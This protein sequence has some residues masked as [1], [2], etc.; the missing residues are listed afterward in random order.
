MNEIS[1]ILISVA[2]GVAI[3]V[4]PS[5]V[6]FGL[7]DKPKISYEAIVKERIDIYRNLWSKIYALQS[8]LIGFVY[9]SIPTEQLKQLQEDFNNVNEYYLI[10]QPF[11]T[12]SLFDKLK[13][14]HSELQSTFEN[15][16]I[17]QS[18][19][20]NKAQE[21]IEA[22][23]KLIAGHFQPIRQEIINQI[24]RDFHIDTPLLKKW[25]LKLKSIKEGI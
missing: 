22:R 24:K 20:G 6:L 19:P 15:L 17:S 2:V 25:K 14:L 4:I 13:R 1:T 3:G 5:Y 16:Y 10:N 7:V 9:Q 12:S 11:I 21:W 23:N 18:N 8:K